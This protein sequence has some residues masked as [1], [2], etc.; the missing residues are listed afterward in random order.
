MHIIADDPATTRDIPSF[1]EFMDHQLIQKEVDSTPYHYWIKKAWNKPQAV[2]FSHKIAN[3]CTKSTACL[4]NDGE[5][6]PQNRH[7]H[8]RKIHRHRRTHLHQHSDLQS[9]FP[10]PHTPHRLFQLMAVTLFVVR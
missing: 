9:R 2:D 5:V 7:F 8:H 1:C 6:R 4:I 10:S 3:L